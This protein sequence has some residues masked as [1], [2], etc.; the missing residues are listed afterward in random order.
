MSTEPLILS[1]D[2][3]T[4]GG[5]VCLTRGKEIIA[6]IIGEATIS[7]SNALLRDINQI[8]KTAG[9]TLSDVDLFACAAGPGSF[10]GLRIGLATVKA[11]SMTLSR[12]CIGIP[13]LQAI[14]HSCG[15]ANVVVAAQ[16]AGRGEVFA[17]LLSVSSDGIVKELDTPSHV[18]PKAMIEKY[19]ALTNLKW[20]GEG[21]RLYQDRIRDA[22]YER[23]IEF[24]DE[25]V[26]STGDGRGWGLAG[27]EPNLAKEI[28]ALALQRCQ[29]GE[30]GAPNSLR[31]IY[32]RLSDAE[33]KEQCQQQNLY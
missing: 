28:A 4:L 27:R 18:S 1:V 26:N 25:P 10:T 13:T 11:F 23:T 5:S 7:H 17:Q 12:P 33:L 20:A 8:L 30:P 2:T 16:P 21:A 15:P 14:A 22:A 9:V 29:G 32:V 3:A 19:G 31:A 24:R 6:S